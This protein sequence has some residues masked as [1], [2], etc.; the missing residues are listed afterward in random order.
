[1]TA[2]CTQCGSALGASTR[3]CTSCGLENAADAIQGPAPAVGAGVEPA[4]AALAGASKLNSSKPKK[5]R[6]WLWWILAL[7]LVF[8]LG[9]LL[10]R[11]MAPKCPHC[12]A[13]PLLGN[14]GGGGGGGGAGGGKPGAGPGSPGGGGAGG[15]GGG[16]GIGR[17][18]GDGGNVNGGGGSGSAGSGSGEGDVE[19][20]GGANASG[21]V[22]GHGYDSTAGGGNGTDDS[23]TGAG[24]GKTKLGD[25]PGDSGP[26]ADAKRT[27]AGVWRLAAGGTLS[28]DGVDTP[29]TSAQ[30]ASG[31]VLTAH[32]F[33]YDK[34][35]LPR[36]PDS[37][38]AV[39]SAISYPPGDRT[40]IYGTSSGIVTSSSFDTVVDWY[41][42]NLPPGWH[43]TTIRDLG[44]LAKQLSPEYI[45]KMF[46]SQADGSAAQ[47]GSAASAAAPP[48]KLKISIFRPPA[49]SRADTGV[50]IIQKG[51]QPVQAFMQ[52][53][54]KP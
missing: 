25:D 54:V 40:D 26:S 38:T 50:M 17:V 9:M 35:N 15:G 48:E 19:G 12:P 34:T 1:M 29:L 21:T 51:D 6:R 32:D 52:T 10:G 8:A 41:G 36:Y 7:I 3:Y 43:A 45:L 28:A 47:P 30:Q 53:N 37:V 24:G 13:A 16:A 27:E 14:G 11:M 4:D 22:V 39:A 18:L 46:G 44:S 49:G 5:T 23:D 33:R 2:F 20:G 42:K 31:K